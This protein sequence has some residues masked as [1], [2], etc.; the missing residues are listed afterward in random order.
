MHTE[1]S[2]YSELCIESY[3]ADRNNNFI[4]DLKGSSLPPPPMKA[5]SPLSNYILHFDAEYYLLA[6]NL[7][8][9][10]CKFVK[11]NISISGLE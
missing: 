6:S 9:L 11:I 4:I 10:K 3:S 2:P 7:S 5:S 8:L 1:F